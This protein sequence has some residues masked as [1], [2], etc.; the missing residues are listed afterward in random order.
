MD[1]D[2]VLTCRTAHLYVLPRHH[3]NNQTKRSFFSPL[4]TGL[5]LYVLTY[6]VSPFLAF[7]FVLQLDCEC[8]LKGPGL[9]RY[10]LNLFNCTQWFIYFAG[11]SMNYLDVLHFDCRNAFN[12]SLKN[13]HVKRHV[14]ISSL[15]SSLF[16]I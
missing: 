16:S 12:D 10:L 7:G 13:I 9:F 4:G 11:L 6:V 5:F 3:R 8:I 14:G 15:Q 1:V 2:F